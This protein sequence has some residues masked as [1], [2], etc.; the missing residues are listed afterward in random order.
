MQDN[1]NTKI[2]F[3]SDTF[4]KYFKNTS[5]LFFE[6]IIRVI[7]GA[8]VVISITNYLGPSDFGL[9]SYALSFAGIFT[10]IATL[11]IDTIL[12]REL[13]NNK[14]RMNILLGT[15]LGL[16]LIG[17]L[18]SLALLS[19]ALIF[20]NQDRFTNFLIFIIALSP[21][22]QSFNVVDSYFQS[23]VQSKY[24]VIAQSSSFIISSVIKL[25][26]I[27]I[28][29]SLLSFVVFTT[30]EYVFLAIT[31]LITY[32]SIGLNIFDWKFEMKLAITF[33][34]DSW[35]LILSGIVITIYMKI[36]QIMIKQML[37]IAEVGY[38]AAAVRLSEAWYFLPLIITS[39]LFPAIVITKN[40]N[41]KLFLSRMQK[42]YDLLAWISISIALLT[43]FFSK[44]I[45]DILYKPEFMPAVP[46]LTIYIWA[47]V[48]VFL[49][50]A[51][52]QF[53]IAEN[54]TKIAFYR[55]FIGMVLNVILNYFLIP[56]YGIVG[57]ALATLIS[58]SV[59]TFFLFFNIKTRIQTTLMLKSVLFFD[60][61]KLIK[62]K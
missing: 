39:S 14:E 41:E 55:S 16:K 15:G 28:N 40:I 58:Y 1:I 18:I 42:L 3:K 47:G 6:K 56:K 49:G 46:V 10:V 62:K 38:Y 11:G 59:A 34:K 24:S 52:T 7:L 17:A 19:I 2:N 45:I 9:Y 8:F 20:T 33:L 22:F 51:S 5:W 12:T 36:D 44:E 60:L 30:A 50:V 21:I 48:F 53:L 31:Y 13:I 26:L 35:P 23:K 57:S 37:G 4:K 25:A 54:F 32:K 43:T 61:F 27:I 29:S